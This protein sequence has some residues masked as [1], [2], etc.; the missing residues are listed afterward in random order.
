MKSFE[1]IECESG[2]VLMTCSMLLE[3]DAHVPSLDFVF[4]D[5]Q[6]PVNKVFVLSRNLRV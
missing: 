6:K 3:N 5:S 2:G 1:F 4:E